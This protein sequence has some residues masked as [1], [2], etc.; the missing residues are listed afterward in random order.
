[1]QV[2]VDWLKQYT[3][4]KASAHEI[5]DRLTMRVNEVDEVRSLAGLKD[6]VVAEVT[7]LK[8]HP[9]ADNLWVAEVRAGS[10][11]HRVVAGADNLAVGEKVPLAKPGVV[12]PGGLKVAVRTLRGVKSEGMLCSP[13]ELGAGEDH[14]GIWLLPAD[15]PVGKSLPAALGGQVDSFDLDVPANR[16]DLMGHLGIAREVAAAFGTALREPK[17]RTPNR[18]RRGVFQPKI[19][20]PGQCRRFALA[21]IRGFKN[22]QSPDWIQARL[23]SVGLRP[24]NAVVD[25]TN[26]VMLETGQPLHAYDFSKL[27]GVMMYVRGSRPDESLKTL[28]GQTRKLPNGTPVIADRTQ[29]LG[30]AGIMGGANSEVTKRTD[31]LVLEC[32]SFD[33]ATIRR[34]SRRLGLRTDASARFEKG[35][36]PELVWPTIRRAIDLILETGGGELVELVDTYPRRQRSQPIALTAERVERFL[37]KAVP[38]APAKRSLERLGFTVRST[39]GKL[40]ATPPYWRVDVLTESDVIE[41]LARS[42]GYDTLPSTL[43]TAQ[44][45]VPTR[46]PLAALRTALRESL[47]ECGLTEILTHSLLGDELLKKAGWPNGELVRMA[48]PLSADHA[49]L[50]GSL[51]PRHL[52]AVADNL[53]WRDTLGLF[54]LG[55]VFG[56]AGSK[57]APRETSRLLVTLA[58]QGSAERFSDVRGILTRLLADWHIPEDDVALEAVDCRKFAPGRHFRISVRGTALGCFGDYR[59]P[60][61]FKAGT[62]AMLSINLGSLSGVLPDTWRVTNPPAFPAVGRDLSLFL[63]DDASYAELRELIRRAAGPLLRS[64]GDPEEFRRQGKRSLTVKLSFGAADRTLTDAEVGKAMDVVSAAVRRRGWK[65]RE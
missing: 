55:N 48:N 54:E 29:T 38:L 60:Q 34:A 43:P 1:M 47:V 37:G 44:L 57:S 41:E 23:T 61:R 49:Y 12:L 6:I 14:S 45:A 17:L 5:A 18:K 13:R 30:I 46:P 63:P 32:A 24:I 62:V 35:L 16:P 19:T 39:R 4:V 9:D 2:S 51:G 11:T 21:R 64:V 3:S 25:I 65:I 20:D 27:T 42:I 31:D 59:Y 22:G 33:A 36:P 52:E 50:R 56:P 53:R 7:S 58:S 28:D 10:K 8:R 40:T 26:F 15:A